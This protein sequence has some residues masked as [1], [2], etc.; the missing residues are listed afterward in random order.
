MVGQGEGGLRQCWQKSRNF[1]Q[2]RASKTLLIFGAEIRCKVA[3]NRPGH[4]GSA[5]AQ[6]SP[7]SAEWATLKG[8]CGSLSGNCCG[9]LLR[10]GIIHG[11]GALR[12]GHFHGARLCP[13]QQDGERCPLADH[14][15]HPHASA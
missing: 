9:S 1:V 8:R 6:V 12:V 5:R 4:D 10:V 11:G 13:R 14:A 2:I 7:S 15:V 3:T